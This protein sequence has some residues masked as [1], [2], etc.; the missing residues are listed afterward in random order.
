MNQQQ[1]QDFYLQ[2]GNNISAARKAAG[3]SQEILGDQLSL[4]RASIVNIEKGRHRLMIHVLVEIA[5]ALKVDLSTL[6]P[7]KKVTQDSGKLV[8]ASL[9]NN[10]ITDQE[11]VDPETARAVERFVSFLN[12]K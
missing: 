6:L 8:A 9:S 5:Q 1:E 4:S 11:K 3:L 10:I 12:N 7:A 2:I